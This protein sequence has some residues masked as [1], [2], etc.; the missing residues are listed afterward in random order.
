MKILSKVIASSEREALRLAQA[1]Q[2]L[3]DRLKD[4]EKR[5]I[6]HIKSIKG[7]ANNENN[8]VTQP[9]ECP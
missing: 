4:A 5:H 9:Y 3:E 8:K 1:E 6:N 7:K 2:A